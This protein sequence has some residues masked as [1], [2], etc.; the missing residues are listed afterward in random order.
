M[1]KIKTLVAVMLITFSVT[2]QKKQ[3]DDF[4]ECYLAAAEITFNLAADK[5]DQLFIKFLEEKLEHRAEI[6]KNIKSEEI[7]KEEVKA[8]MKVVNQRYFKSVAILTDKTKK[9]IMAFEKKTN[10]KCRKN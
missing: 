5:K 10:K 1:K 8:K 3:K 9:E 2:A 7:S 4:Q 6:R